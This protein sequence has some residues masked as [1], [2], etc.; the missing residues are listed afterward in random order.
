MAH[1]PHHEH[2]IAEI[3]EMFEPVFKNSPQAIYIYL[4]D[5]HKICND[6][7]IKLLGY[8]SIKEWVDNEYPVDDIDPKDQE[9][10][11]KA[12]MDASRK[13]KAS[14]LE[15]TWVRKDGKK[16]QTEVIM[17]PITYKNEVFV[18]HFI[19]VKK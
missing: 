1:D 13:L 17:A 15:G 16:I 9:K 5:E 8:K 7:F 14:I 4:D 10:G 2:L 3:A 11:I 6:K 12:Y 18:I 19:S